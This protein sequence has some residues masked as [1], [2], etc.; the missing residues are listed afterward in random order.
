MKNLWHN[1]YYV[2]KLRLNENTSLEPLLTTPDD[3]GMGHIVEVDLKHLHNLK[4][5]SKY[6]PFCPKSV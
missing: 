5:K 4:Q 3:V 1:V 6:L 2:Q